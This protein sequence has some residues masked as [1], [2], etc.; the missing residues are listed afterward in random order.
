[1]IV[2]LPPPVRLSAWQ[3][4]VLP[5]A[6]FVGLTFAQ[7]WLGGAA[8]Y[9]IYL[10]KTAVGAALLWLVWPLVHEM[11]WRCSFEGV[12]AGIVV[13]GVWVGL[14]PLY[15]KLGGAAT[16]WNPHAVLGTD[17]VLAWFFVVVR[18]TGSSLVVPPLE[19]VFY[20]SFLYRYFAKPDFESIP[21]GVFLPWPF[22]GTV[23]VFGLA[24]PQQWLAALFCAAVYQGLVCWRRRL[25]DAMTAHAVTNLLLG[26]WVA[27]KGAW[28]FW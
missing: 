27:W 9:W 10:L 11:R 21:L 15:P 20:R 16:P 12:L 5:F 2:P 14:D 13:V 25:G 28:A 1:M 19:E 3:V 17:S 22:L 26:S 18:V 24:H 8:P 6:V 4:R 23:V 7:G